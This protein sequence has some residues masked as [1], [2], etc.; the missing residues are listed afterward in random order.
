M[1]PVL[2][3]LF[4]RSAWLTT[5]FALVLCASFHAS[6]FDD[7]DKDKKPRTRIKPQFAD[8]SQRMVDLGRQPGA[9]V[10]QR[11]ADLQ[12]CDAERRRHEPAQ[13]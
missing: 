13:V 5:S 2:H 11:G 8:R 1:S 7:K 3:R 6:G 4:V 9:D 10:A 12:E